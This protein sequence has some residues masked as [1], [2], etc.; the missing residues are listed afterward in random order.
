MVFLAVLGIDWA[1]YDGTYRSLKAF[2]RIPEDIDYRR[3]IFPRILLTLCA[4]ALMSAATLRVEPD[5]PLAITGFL[6]FLIASAYGQIRTYLN[7]KRYTGDR[8][9]ES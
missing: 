2:Y 8:D 1:L 7:A 3:L 5:V 4:A 6:L 9:S